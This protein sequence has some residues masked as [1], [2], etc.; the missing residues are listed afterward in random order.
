MSNNA[1]GYGSKRW[2]Q[3]ETNIFLNLVSH[4]SDIEEP[5]ATPE[6]RRNAW[7]TIGKI[8]NPKTV[9]ECKSQLE[10]LKNDNGRQAG[11]P[12]SR[13]NLQ[14]AS[15]SSDH[16]NTPRNDGTEDSMERVLQR[17][18]IYA[19]ELSQDKQIIFKQIVFQ[20]LNLL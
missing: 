15:T 1:V 6:A 16:T 3:R 7:E 4:F 19:E 20:L 12:P 17:I 14:V 2:T 9:L 11:K 8:M 5:N 18:E 13:R 10:R